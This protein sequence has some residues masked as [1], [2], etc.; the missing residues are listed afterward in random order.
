[1]PH[2]S[3]VR[4]NSVDLLAIE[5]YLPWPSQIIDRGG[6]C[7]SAAKAWL[8]AL[9]KSRSARRGDWSPPSWLRDLY[10]WGP[11][12]WPLSWCEVPRAKTLDCGALAAVAAYLLEVR[13]H[14]VFRVQLA[15]R[16]PAEATNGWR[17]AWE[18]VGS[19]PGWVAG[20]LC[21]HEAVAVE[22]AMG[23]GST[24][25]VVRVWD[26]TDSVWIDPSWVGESGFAATVSIR[27][28]IP[29]SYRTNR[30]HLRWGSHRLTI[31]TWER[32]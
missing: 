23:E 24:E 14:R 9:D 27:F 29:S 10:G 25:A 18:V 30:T 26:P 16:Y 4:I 8:T 32:L 11:I 19:D 6:D 15:A 3:D 5:Q 31:G 12:Q 2:H 7:C 17:R 13:E 21:Y 1:M 20:R 22:Q 28:I